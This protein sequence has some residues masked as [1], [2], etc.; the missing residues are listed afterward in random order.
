MAENLTQ[1]EAQAAVDEIRAL[2]NR[3]GVALVGACSM[4]GIYG[5]IWVTRADAS[6][7][8]WDN[9]PAQLTNRVDDAIGAGLSS[10]GYVDGIG[11]A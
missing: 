8:G 6:L 9:W 5:E 3:L 1:A 4:E 11:D 2:C 7:K 10:G